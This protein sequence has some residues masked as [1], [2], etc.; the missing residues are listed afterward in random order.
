MSKLI[1]CVGIPASGKTTWAK[2]YCS[3]NEKTIRVN[4][5]DIRAMM[6]QT[7][8]RELEKVV[9][10]SEKRIITTALVNG[11][12]VVVDDTNLH[13]SAINMIKE[14]IELSG[15]DV[16]IQTKLFTDVE[17]NTCIERDLKRENP[18]GE[19]V[20]N[21]MYEIAKNYEI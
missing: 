11:F 2:Q 9:R 20:I 14:A 18:V 10:D 16:D 15:M 6:F 1:I 13:E 8:N 21:R 3:E 7:Y 4:R 5:D 12:D 19:S 17:L